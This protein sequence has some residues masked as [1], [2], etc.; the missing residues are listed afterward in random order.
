MKMTPFSGSGQSRVIA[1][2]A[3]VSIVALMCA[4]CSSTTGGSTQPS[5]NGTAQSSS[6]NTSTGTSQLSATDFGLSPSPQVVS[7]LPSSVKSQG[8]LVNA[9]YN[10]SPPNDLVKNGKLVGVQVDFANAVSELMGVKFRP[11]ILGSFSS[12]IPGL[13]SKR[14][15]LSFGGFGITSAREQ[16]VNLIEF[17]K[18]GMQFAVASDSKLSINSAQDLCGLTVAELAGSNYIP[19]TQKLS[20]TCTKAGK[21]PITIKQY[22]TDSASVLALK[23]GRVDAYGQN[24]INVSYEAQQTGGIK[25]EPFLDA[26][27]PQG[28]AVP[29]GS[30]L[31]RAVQAALKVLI[32]DG[33]YAKILSK[34]HIQNVAVPASQVVLDPKVSV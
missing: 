26:T 16:V 29:K 28:V 20:S 18:V 6:P 17:Y 8:V 23:N 11:V 34:W 32:A 13:Q 22:P 14:Y 27:T 12:L 1:P 5:T 33:T 3:L 15:N 19:D 4:A 21:K 31:T 7:L 2:I 24:S 9:M 10:N 25:V 30:P